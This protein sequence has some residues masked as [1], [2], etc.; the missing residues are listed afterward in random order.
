M[1]TIFFAWACAAVFSLLGC[2]VEL[3]DPEG[4]CVPELV[5]ESEGSVVPNERDPIEVVDSW[6]IYACE[7]FPVNTLGLGSQCDAHAEC[8]GP[9][10]ICVKGLLPCDTPEVGRC[11][12]RCRSDYE[13]GRELI[14]TDAVP[15]LI[16][17]MP[18]DQLSVCIPSACVAEIPGWDTICGPLD[19]QAVNALGIG[20]GC[21][22]SD[23]CPSDTFC[24]GGESAER[25][26]TR[27][28]ESDVDCGEAAACVCVEDETCEEQ[29]FVCAPTE[30]CVDAVRHHHC[31]GPGVPPREHGAIC[32]DH[33][34]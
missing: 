15:E 9:D 7:G 28:C 18:Q 33:H 5:F 2:K 24:P 19:G 12:Q 34:D 26:C 14:E 11:T 25:Y 31:R 4:V 29:F 8:A 17:A 22:S 30:N 20:L 32:G 21:E 10:Q 27:M 16:C 6:L 1:K 3:F 23:D 13:C